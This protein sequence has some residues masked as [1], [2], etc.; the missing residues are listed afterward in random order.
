MASVGVFSVVTV[1]LNEMFWCNCLN[2]SVPRKML[3]LLH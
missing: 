2:T 3:S 1:A